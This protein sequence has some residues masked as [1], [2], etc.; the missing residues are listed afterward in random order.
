MTTYTIP[1]NY[2]SMLP[3]GYDW[4]VVK[5]PTRTDDEPGMF[6]GGFFRWTDITPPRRLANEVES[7]WPDGT[8]FRHIRTGERILIQSGNPVC[9]GKA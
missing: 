4:R 9:L 6:Y 8:E 3:R 2:L 7:P 5:D 1:S